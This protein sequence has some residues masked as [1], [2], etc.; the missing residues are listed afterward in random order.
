MV[1]YK[2]LGVIFYQKNEPPPLRPSCFAY[3][4]SL[5]DQYPG[6]VLSF[7]VS[8]LCIATYDALALGSLNFTDRP[9][10][11]P[12]VTFFVLSPSLT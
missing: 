4:G 9:D 10:V 2:Y 7:A 3:L 8:Q 11:S 12:N 5:H 1:S 6:V